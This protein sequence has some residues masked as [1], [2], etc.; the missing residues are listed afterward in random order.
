[1]LSAD[2]LEARARLEEWRAAALG[3]LIPWNL[4]CA[5]LSA[6]VLTSLAPW[7]LADR[8][9]L[10][11]G[12]LLVGVLALL[13]AAHRLPWRLRTVLFLAV[14]FGVVLLAASSTPHPG[15]AAFAHALALLSLAGLLLGSRAAV[16][17]AVLTGV[18]LALVFSQGLGVAAAAQLAPQ[19]PRIE[20]AAALG[21][22]F[23][24][25][26]LLLLAMRHQTRRLREALATGA[27]AQRE[28]EVARAHLAEA[29]KAQLAGRLA[30][31]LAHD[32]NNTLTVVV[33]NSA[34]L[35][36]R[37]GDEE[38]T[39]AAAQICE[40]SRNAATLTQQVLL[41][42]RTGMAQPRP[43]ELARATGAAAGALRRL[44]PPDIQVETRLAGPVWTHFD[45]GQLQQILL[46]LALNARAA[47]PGGGTLL[48]AVRPGGGPPQ[49]PGE[50]PP[51]AILEV[52]DTGFGLDPEERRRAFDPPS[53]RDDRRGGGFGL[54]GVRALAEEGGGHVLLRSVPG[55]GT[56]VTLTLPGAVPPG[57]APGAEASSAQARVLVVEDDIRVRALIC[58][59]LTEAGH[60]VSEVA[61]GTQAMRAIEELGAVDL[62][63]TDVI[64]PG[65]P[66][67]EVIE[68][69][70]ARHPGGRILVCSAFSED[71]GIRRRVYAGE[72]QLLPK[73]FTRNDL[74]VEV[75][76]I[77]AGLAREERAT[78]A[79]PPR[80]GVRA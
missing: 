78:P 36:E 12:W 15:A 18:G 32:L 75:R 14:N 77:L 49:A 51:A 63:V 10:V 79:P 52:S 45:P 48:F 76:S 6:V 67:S 19:D 25:V 2:P 46:S 38:V 8:S 43:L 13:A 72:Y 27:G 68:T 57:L 37:P 41:A 39:E 42:S 20:W 33:A 34:W 74:L 44:L 71:E 60:L 55:T 66:V 17:A 24:A 50:P 26:V 3:A 62:L 65:A 47:M 61:D 69:Y 58:T 35:A 11:A 30:G 31:A 1:V 4:G 73:P 7:T 64:M 59:A 9:G 54:T 5:A 16:A 53:G 28:L 80:A 70:R 23:P 56:V 21:G 40:A 29:E 22:S